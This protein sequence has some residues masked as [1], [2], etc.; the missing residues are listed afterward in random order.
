[1]DQL[2]DEIAAEYF[3]AHE[4]MTRLNEN[5][6]HV[7]TMRLNENS[8]HVIPIAA[9]ISELPNCGEWKRSIETFE[10]QLSGTLAARR[11]QCLSRYCKIDKCD[12]LGMI[13][14]N[15]CTVYQHPRYK[16]LQYL[17]YHVFMIITK[18]STSILA[19]ADYAS[20]RQ[21]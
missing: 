10:H 14:G 11:N 19:I 12:D 5:S 21:A 3:S 8:P 17:V 15:I 16:N 7:I 18:C 20:P 9:C 1:V 6:P 13:P 2:N 4:S